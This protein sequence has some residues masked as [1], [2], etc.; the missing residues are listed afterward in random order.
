[1]RISFIGGGNMG[2]AMLSAIIDKGLTT[3]EN[4]TVS[5][6]NNARLQQ[7]KEDFSVNISSNLDIIAGGEIIILAIKPQNL[8]E[9]MT[10]VSGQLAP[11]Q[12]VLSIIAGRSIASLRQGLKHNAIVRAMPNTPAQI[13]QGMTVWTAT[14]EVTEKQRAAVSSIL[15][16]MGKEVYVTDEGYIDMA[17]AVSGSGPAYI[18]LFMESLINAAVELG[19]P[20]ETAHELVLQTVTG[21][22]EYASQSDKGLAQLRE[23]VTSPGGTTAEAIKTLETGTFAELVKKAVAAA[24]RRARELGG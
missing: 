4:I 14:D 5:D 3:S 15:G 18:F 23:M 12:L 6:K 13:G 19:L 24:Y 16:A 7:L 21:S 9:V 20:P 2:R 17:T 8:D 11:G 1:M 22:A 10:E